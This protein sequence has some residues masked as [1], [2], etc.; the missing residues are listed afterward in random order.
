MPSITR[1]NT[2]V[3]ALL[4][5]MTVVVAMGVAQPIALGEELTDEKI[6]QYGCSGEFDY[7]EMT[8]LFF[9]SSPAEV[10]LRW[11]MNGADR[12]GIRLL[13]Q[14][15][16]AGVRYTDGS[17][18]FWVKGKSATYQRVMAKGAVPYKC[19]VLKQGS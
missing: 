16:A 10:V 2:I 13:R 18:S 4:V 3:K 19:T 9:D 5:P 6:V 1:L 17:Q 11:R 15:S 7:R 8:V 14:R 12:G